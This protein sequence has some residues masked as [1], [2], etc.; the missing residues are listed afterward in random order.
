M[1]DNG[2]LAHQAFWLT[3]SQVT[4]RVKDVIQRS[5]G[6]VWVQGELSGVKLH[7]PSGHLYFS[8]KDEACLIRAVMFRRHATGLPFAPVDGEMV[9]AYGRVTVFERQG[10]YQLVV[11]DM[12]PAGAKG[13]AALRLEL[14]KAK[15]AAEGLFDPSRKRPLPR[16]P[17]ALGVVTSPTGAAISDIIKVATRRWPAVRIVVSPAVVQGEGASG[18][19]VK[20]IEILD[21]ANLVDVMIV[22]RGGGG[23]EDLSCFSDETVVRAIAACR[24]PVVSAVGHE[25][26]MTL[27]DLAADARASTPSAAAE[28]VVPERR[29]IEVQVGSLTVR[30]KRALSAHAAVMREQVR[31]LASSHGLRSPRNVVQQRAVRVDDLTARLRVAASTGVR[32]H[33]RTVHAQQERLR[34]LDPRAVLARGYALCL[35]H[36]TRTI[37]NSVRALA[38]NQTVDV[39]LSDGEAACQVTRPSLFT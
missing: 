5:V 34:A 24:T 15:L 30:A 4:E 28:M 29:D 31:R 27:A 36:E 3:V 22:G 39:I 35:D 1:P 26:D 18:T 11:E 32:L 13:L 12:V 37:V 33:A 6:E 7:Q 14:L 10:Q 19:I 38:P 17:L 25:V 16:F 21:R 2:G 9:L 8:L 23:R 20:A